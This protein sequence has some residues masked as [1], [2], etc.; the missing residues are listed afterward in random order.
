MFDTFSSDSESIWGYDTSNWD[1]TEVK[2][3][4]K[5]PVARWRRVVKDSSVPR[6]K[7]D[8]NNAVCRTVPCRNFAHG[9]CRFGDN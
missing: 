2:E 5:A 8:P 1:W 7:V 4:V 9:D 6:Q 3:H